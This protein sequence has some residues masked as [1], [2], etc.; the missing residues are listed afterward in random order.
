MC[1]RWA[2]MSWSTALKAARMVV[3]MLF[4]DCTFCMCSSSTPEMFIKYDRTRR[5]GN[6]AC[7]ASYASTGQWRYLFATL[8]VCA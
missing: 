4:G 5:V 7:V 2:A 3:A 6:L 1:W 8:V